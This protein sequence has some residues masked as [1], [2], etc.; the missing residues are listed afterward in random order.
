MIEVILLIFYISVFI[1]IEKRFLTLIVQI[2]NLFYKNFTFS[3][4]Q[5]YFKFKYITI[6]IIIILLEYKLNIQDRNI[7]IEAIININA[8]K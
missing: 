4:N 5:Y 2:Q 3:N 6:F 1:F 7:Y 8:K